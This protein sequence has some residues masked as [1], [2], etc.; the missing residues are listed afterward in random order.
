MLRIAKSVLVAVLAIIGSQATAM[1]CAEDA[2]S[3]VRFESADGVQLRGTFYPGAVDSPCVL[4]IHEFGREVASRPWIE[5]AESLHKRGMAVLRF[6]L[7]GHGESTEVEPDK[8]WLPGWPNR[9]LVKTRDPETI[10]YR[11]FDDRY[12]P[13][14]VQDLAAAKAYLDRRNDAGRC[15]SSNLVVVA[16]E[17][18]ATLASLWVNAEWRR[19]RVYPA[20]AFGMLP[21]VEEEPEGKRILAAVL[22]DAAGKVGSQRVDLSSTLTLP[23]RIGRMPIALM[24]GSDTASAQRAKA[25]E[26]TLKA[27]GLDLPF[28]GAAAVTNAGDRRG[29][30]LLAM[31][32]VQDAIGLFIEEVHDRRS[33]EWEDRDIASA[34]FMQRN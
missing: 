27:R 25:A 34:T 5:L 30:L 12:L 22:V 23:G 11:D 31:K 20:A 10:S 26:R 6:D 1:V 9:N 17:N 21:R 8:F 13:F 4:L 14:L 28:T 2:G 32:P 24:Y 19:H 15:N 7:R 18:G 3:D 29:S 33:R 16:A